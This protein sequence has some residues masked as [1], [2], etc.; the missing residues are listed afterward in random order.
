MVGRDYEAGGIAKDGAKLVTAVSCARVPKL[1]VI[2]GGSFGAGNYGMCGR[3]YGPRFLFMWPNAR[4][5]VMG[6]EQAAAVMAEVGQPEPRRRAAR[7]VRAPG[8]RGL[9]DG[10][11]LGRRRDR[12]ARHPRGARAG[13]RRDHAGPAPGRRLRRLSDVTEDQETRRASWRAGLRAGVPYAGAGFLLS[14]SFG[15]LSKGVGFTSLEAILTSVIVFAGSAQFAAVSILGA[16]GGVG[17]VVIAVALVN[18]RFL[19][20]GIA[21]APSLPGGPFKRA[22][23]GQPI[24]DASW[25]MASRD[26]GSF[27]R[28]FLFGA[29]AIQYVTWQLGTLAGVLAGGALGDPGKYGLDAIYPTFFLALLLGEL[30]TRRAGGVA[31]GGALLALVLIPFTPAGVPVLAAALAAFAGAFR[32]ERHHG[33]GA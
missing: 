20:M 25:A 21:L 2:V 1:T 30:K 5:S 4:I 23:Q 14:L 18:A 31:L 19:A 9:L 8:P 33:T 22:L 27:D 12:S 32:R 6:G 26:D 7:P 10:A 17:A 15:V 24:V 3:A 11:D 28:F 13:T 16:G 29:T